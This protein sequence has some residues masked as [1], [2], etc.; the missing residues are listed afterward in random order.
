MLFM[1]FL[2]MTL[3]M[4]SCSKDDDETVKLSSTI[5]INGS[6]VNVKSTEAEYLNGYTY[7]LTF[8]INDASSDFYI[9]GKVRSQSELTPNT[10]IT[11]NCVMT[12]YSNKNWYATDKEYVSGSVT[13][14]KLDMEKF[15]VVLVY[16]D[17]KCTSG[18]N[19]ITLNGSVTFPLS[20]SK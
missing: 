9:Q 4:M 13:L 15:R 8:W 14:E 7:P 17:Y 19:S 5:T 12:I 20:I 11:K 1:S 10:D 3:L 16:K 18:S 2:L 6:V